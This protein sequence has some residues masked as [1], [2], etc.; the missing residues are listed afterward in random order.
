MQHL[1]H[2]TAG[3]VNEYAKTVRAAR[4]FSTRYR[5]TLITM[6]RRGVWPASATARD[7]LTQAVNDGQG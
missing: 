6:G 5:F 3:R 1:P 4:I 7:R 2:F